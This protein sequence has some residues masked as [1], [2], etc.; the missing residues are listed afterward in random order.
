MR[1]AGALI[2]LV[3]FIT[4]GCAGNDPSKE[5]NGSSLD[6]TITYATGE[7][8]ATVFE[9]AGTKRYALN[10]MTPGASYELSISGVAAGTWMNL[11][12][13]SD[14]TFMVPVAT[15]RAYGTGSGLPAR[16][17]AGASGAAWLELS[18]GGPTAAT[19]SATTSA[20][21]ALDATLVF[22]SDLPFTGPA[23]NG[24]HHYR[25]TGLTPGTAYTAAV[26][27]SY[28]Y[29]A[30]YADGSF[31]RATCPKGASC[32]FIADPNG[33]GW[34]AVDDGPLAGFTLD[35]TVRPAVT[36]AATITYPANSLFSSTVGVRETLWYRVTG[37]TGGT[38]WSIRSAGGGGSLSFSVYRDEA[39]ADLACSSMYLCFV[40]LPSAGDLYVAVDGGSF[41]GAF[42]LLTL[43]IP[44]PTTLVYA[45]GATLSGSVDASNSLIEVTGL[46][47][48]GIYTVQLTGLTDE[49]DFQ[50]YGDAGLTSLRNFGVS[51]VP[52]TA[53]A[54]SSG[55]LYVVVF[56]YH[57]VEPAPYT[58]SP[59][60]TPFT[61]SV[62]PGAASYTPV[63]Y[64]PM[65]P[66]S[67]MTSDLH[68]DVVVSGLEPGFGY[69]VRNTTSAHDV[70]VFADPELTTL[71][72]GGSSAP[73]SFETA[74]DLTAPA[75]GI[76]YV[77]LTDY[78]GQVAVDLDIR[79]IP[80]HVALP[81][82]GLPIAGR[83]DNSY[84]DYEITG[85][86]A[87]TP[88]VVSLSQ[89]GVTRWA[90]LYVYAD[91]GHTPTPPLCSSDT[92][93][94]ASASCAATPTSSTL[95]VVVV[96]S[97]HGVCDYTLDV[98]PSP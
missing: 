19:L 71:L 69:S 90:S 35:V 44:S 87:G 45:L 53:T 91:A 75:S 70:S 84:T 65:F 89:T 6:G 51:Q 18:A 25:I 8:L 80:G 79:G 2:T 17:V 14:A 95:Y 58:F 93:G 52:F 33:E 7:L 43:P 97:D 23:D 72:C 56:G 63:Q 64:G 96:V 94:T 15:G 86:A 12:I 77:D 42:D 50:T 57:Y 47:P 27:G 81:L 29:V 74:C 40:P 55:R 31:A 78:W 38:I 82:S 61:L 21:P 13:A 26:S 88:Y 1:R 62:A 68:T 3:G 34:L 54:S 28:D 24:Y 36:T 30:A 85:V 92:G 37:L 9:A 48:G 39:G 46:T 11:T 67:E 83:M 22:P 76:V 32:G 5:T 49:L 4:A 16:F 10:G 73:A 59:A 98:Q 66:V 60:T 41:G 20:P